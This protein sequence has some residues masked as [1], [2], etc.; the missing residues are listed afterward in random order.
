MDA[1]P[2]RSILK[3]SG[4]TSTYNG[5]A[6]RESDSGMAGTNN[7][8]ST[9]RSYESGDSMSGSGSADLG[10]VSVSMN[11]DPTATRQ[12]GRSQQPFRKPAYSNQG[13]YGDGPDYDGHHPQRQQQQQQQQAAPRRQMQSHQT[14]SGYDMYDKQPPSTPSA[15][16]INTGQGLITG[17]GLLSYTSPQPR[18]QTTEVHQQSSRSGGGGGGWGASRQGA[19]NTAYTPDHSVSTVSQQYHAATTPSRQYQQQ[20]TYQQRTP[21]P[22]QTPNNTSSTEV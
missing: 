22:Q 5:T 4:S 11:P 1:K 19:S 12:K 20:Y 18:A 8:F 7:S 9:N 2:G 21:T 16:A 6:N 17:H 10:H 3:K 13:Y 14:P 15:P